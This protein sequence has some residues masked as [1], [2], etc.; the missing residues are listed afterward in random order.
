MQFRRR[1]LGK[2][3]EEDELPSLRIMDPYIIAEE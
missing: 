3:Q 2:T 1:M